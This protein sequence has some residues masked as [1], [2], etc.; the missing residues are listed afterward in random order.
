MKSFFYGTLTLLLSG[1]GES[2]SATQDP[3][4]KPYLESFLKE[5]SL[6]GM[7]GLSADSLALQKSNLNVDPT[8]SFEEQGLCTLRDGAP[9]I[10]I[11]EETFASLQTAAKEALLYH[12]FG[13]CLLHREHT[14]EINPDFQSYASLMTSDPV[15]MAESYQAH[16]SAYLDELFQKGGSQ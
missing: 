11:D 8:S 15:G 13:H 5:G 9:L 4:L 7:D 16:R 10:Q 1:C 2:P 6:R 3:E 12:E 14:N